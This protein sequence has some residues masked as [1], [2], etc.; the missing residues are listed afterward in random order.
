MMI[1]WFINSASSLS[2]SRVRSATSTESTHCILKFERE[3]AWKLHR[4]FCRDT[5]QQYIKKVV[6]HAYVY[7][8]QQSSILVDVSVSIVTGT[9]RRQC[10]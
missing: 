4:H 1:S 7:R 10:W 8:I 5:F 2:D 3:G 9:A 6:G